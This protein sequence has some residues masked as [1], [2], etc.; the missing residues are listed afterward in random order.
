MEVLTY[1]LLIQIEFQIIDGAAKDSK[2]AANIKL[3]SAEI[4][5]LF[6]LN[7]LLLKCCKH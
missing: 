2:V 1:E 3:K 5:R 4:K 6:G 7:L